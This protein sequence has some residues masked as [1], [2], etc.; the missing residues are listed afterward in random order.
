ML[1][2]CLLFSSWSASGVR[3]AV[4]YVSPSGSNNNLGNSWAAAKQ[5]IQ[6]AINA[7]A[8][9]DEIWVKAG[10]YLPTLDPDGTQ[11]QRDKTFYLTTKD[12]KLYGGFAGN[13]TVLFQ[14]NAVTNVTTLSGN[15]DAGGN[16]DAYH[17]V[18]T[19]NRTNACVIDGFTITD[20]RAN[21]N[22]SFG[23]YFQK[24][25]GGMFNRTSSP[26]VSNCTFSGN[27]ALNLG[28]GMYNRESNPVISNCTFSY[29]TTFISN[30]TTIS[31]GGGIYNDAG[32]ATVSNCTFSNN[33]ARANGGGIYNSQ[34]TLVISNCNFTSNT[35]SN[36]SG[37][38]M[39]N[40][41]STS[42]I[43]GCVFSANVANDP[44]GAGN[45]GGIYNFSSSPATITNCVFSANTATNRG[46]GI[47]TEG[48]SLGNSTITSCVFSANTAEAG[49]GGLTYTSQGS[50][51]ITM[52]SCTFWNNTTPSGFGGGLEIGGTTGGT[53][54]NSVFF[55]NTAPTYT[56][57]APNRQDIFRG[58]GQ[59]PG[60]TVSYSI[61]GDYSATASN[62]Y[63]ANNVL[64]ADPLFI[65]V[66]NPAGMD[67]I[68]RTADDGL[69]IACTSPAKDAGTVTTPINP[70]TDILDSSRVGVIDRGAYEVRAT[71]CPGVLYVNSSKADNSGSGYSWGSAKKDI[72]DAINAAAPGAEIWVKA[73]TYL[74]TLD[75]NGGTSQRDKTFSLTTKD[76]KLYGG[77]AGNETVLSQR[78]PA[79]NVTTLSG[80]LDASGNND[81]YHVL[82]ATN[83]STACVVDGFT[84]TGGRANGGTTFTVSTAG[85]TISQSKGGGMYNEYGSV[86]TVSNCIFSANTAQEGGG[87]YNIS[88]S[89]VTVSKCLFLANTATSLGGGMFNTN[90]SNPTVSNCVFS[91]N[92][93]QDGGGMYN[94]NNSHAALSSCVFSANSASN[95]GGAM[96]NDNGSSPTMSSCTF[97]ANTASVQGGGI[98]YTAVGGGSITNSILYGNTGGPANQQNIYKAATGA[99]LTV[100]SS[101]I[102]DYNAGAT[103]NYTSGAGILTSN[104]LFVNAALPAGTDGKFLTSDDG[105]RIACV[106][107]ARDGGTGT[108]PATDILGKNR[109]GI[110][111]MGAYEADTSCPN[112]LYV[113]GSKADNS[114]NG[115]S[116]TVAKKDIQAAINAAPAGA[117]IWVKGGTYLPTLD[118]NGGTSQRDK[119]FYLTTKDVKLYG[120]FSGTETLLSQRNAT[121]YVTTLSGD[122]DGAGGTADAYHV[123]LTRERTSA[124]VINGFTITGGRA[125]GTGTFAGLSQGNGSG[126]Y[127]TNS[128]PQVSNCIFLANTATS[129]GGGM[130]EDNSSPIVSSCTFSANTAN[131]GGGMYNQ[132]GSSPTVNSCVFSANTAGNVGGGMYNITGS[133]TVSN[134]V[135]TANTAYLGG[136]MYNVNGSIAVGSCTFLNNTASGNAGGIYLTS[137]AGGTITNSIFSGQQNIY[138]LGTAATLT[139]SYSLISDYSAGATNN[140]TSGAGIL[141]SN[142]LFVNASSPAGADGKFGTTDDGL[143][144]QGCSPAINAG[145]G[146]TPTTDILGNSRV[147]AMDLG[148]YEYQSSPTT[149]TPVT[150]TTTETRT[151]AAGSTVVFGGCG[152]AI[153][154]VF[155]TGTTPV[156]G[157]ITAKVYVQATA[158]TAG[159]TPYVRRHYDISPATNAAAA[160]AQLKLYFSQADFDN[161]NTVRGTRPSLPINAAD[162]AGYKANVQITQKHG[163]SA[164]GL[165]GS[166]SGSSVLISPSSVVWNATDLRWEVTFPV[167]GFSGFFAHTGSSA[168]LPL[169]L[170]AFG[171]QRAGEAR[172]RIEWQTTEEE[173][174]TRFF[175]E[176]SGDAKTFSILATVAGQDGKSNSYQSYDEAPL[177]GANYYRLQIT[178]SGNVSYSQTVIVQNEATAAG[179]VTAAPVPATDRIVISCSKKSWKGREAVVLDVQGR[180]QARLILDSQIMLDIAH[181]PAGLYLLRLPDGSSLKLVKQ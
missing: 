171:A 10:T 122:L 46:G 101:I 159:Q 15:L 93:A 100:S 4:I 45:G 131:Y 90:G 87:M 32:S 69:R 26:T 47:R 39:F 5:D 124:C 105:L 123:V 31:A 52:R 89:A 43:T 53:I 160:T 167:T 141:T 147:G 76:V 51:S 165:P 103:N 152:A 71:E 97:S 17:V 115:Y 37:G 80:D 8:P 164:T 119:T 138:K 126:M 108:T 65:D 148:A 170:L 98:Y 174:A 177:E 30:T 133:Q 146:T 70:L 114:A 99:A 77:F 85:A 27:T 151:Q 13:E 130:Y 116:W 83:R 38:G 16:N 81:A 6:D 50:S 60:L 143:A 18:V 157:S 41:G 172:N 33:T 120:G 42:T 140:Y 56:S 22:T 58:Q 168:P 61:V 129:F 84:V 1:L 79:A 139:V 49:G 75:P 88:T 142:P 150:V 74:P 107:P 158:P 68:W 125:N 73:G 113:D 178:E 86:L 156:A 3:A 149:L 44:G 154:Q 20:G 144:L 36:G 132:F 9:G 137:D 169:K 19:L 29:N 176:R 14:R 145:T 104:P 109:V 63:T 24:L 66:A 59:V 135:F 34:S 118:P 48:S 155:S 72:Q 35:A 102:G 106:S 67:G 28:G 112:I 161:Y 40:E 153:A 25:G 12:V 136:A 166:Y 111:D 121:T 57:I 163:T 92:T 162:A 95:K 21:G 62:N 128:S 11:S 91:A 134:S 64:A 94:I 127:N 179:Q 175:V 173:P 82:V 2:S 110:I 54:T 78:N 96:Y 7:A 180:L 117:E 23:L 181:W 55:G